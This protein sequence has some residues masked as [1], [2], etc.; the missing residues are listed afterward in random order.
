MNDLLTVRPHID[1][2]SVV[3]PP[4]LGGASPVHHKYPIRKT[5]LQQLIFVALENHVDT[6][7]F[8]PVPTPPRPSRTRP[9]IAR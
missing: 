5:R 8:H 7:V 1:D 6:V 9:H 2:S 3:A 4:I